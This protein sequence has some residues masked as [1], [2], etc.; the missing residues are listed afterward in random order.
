M[1]YREYIQKSPFEKGY[2]K[3]NNQIN[4]FEIIQEI[5]RENEKITLRGFCKKTGYWMEYIIKNYKIEIIN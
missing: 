1:V 3:Q 2:W 5:E 4:H